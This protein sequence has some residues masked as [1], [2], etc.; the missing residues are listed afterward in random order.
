MAF[1]VAAEAYD[2]FMGRYSRQLGPQMIELAGARP[3]QSALDVGCGPGALTGA[4]VELLGAPA[5]V[6]VDPSASFVAAVRR[7]V[8]GVD[9]RQTSA[10]Q[11]PF[12]ADRF[13]IAIAQ[14]VVHFMA[15]PVARPR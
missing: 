1:D 10:E 13:D 5:V 4:L 8:P 7:R 12:D 3:G 11:L 6:A 9:V 14:L 2:Q 15:D